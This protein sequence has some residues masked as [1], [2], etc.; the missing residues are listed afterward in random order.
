MIFLRHIKILRNEQNGEAGRVSKSGRLGV[1]HI[2]GSNLLK[3]DSTGVQGKLT[4]CNW[5]A[6]GHG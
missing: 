4:K 5:V 2:G 6:V 3:L 1:H